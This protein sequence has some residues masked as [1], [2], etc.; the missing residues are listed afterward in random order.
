M[1][2][3]SLVWPCLFQYIGTVPRLV[4]RCQRKTRSVWNRTAA[5]S[6]IEKKATEPLKTLLLL[7]SLQWSIS[8]IAK[9]NLHTSQLHLQE[10]ILTCERYGVERLPFAHIS[11]SDLTFFE[12]FLP[13]R[14][15][16]DAE[17]LKPF[18]VDWLKSVRGCST[19]LLK[20]RTTMEVSQILKYCN[21]KNLAVNPQGGNTGLVGG[22]VPVFDEIILSTGLMNQIISFDH[23]SGILICQAGCILENLNQYL[24]PKGFVMP[25]DLGAKG[26]CH[27]GGNVATNAG[28]L[29]L[30][31]YGS[32]RGTVLGLEVVLADGSILNCLA[33]LRKDNTG[34]DLKQLFIG[35]EGTLGVVTA[36]SILCPRKPNAVNLAFLACLSFSQVLRTF[37][38]CKDMLGEIL[39]AYE[40]MDNGCM[41]LV[42]RHLKLTNPVTES[43]FYVLIETSGSNSSHDEEKLS[44]FLEHVMGSDLV[45][46]GTLASEGKKI[47]ALWALRE[48]ITEAL[49]CDGVV[50]KYDISLPVEK[51]YDLVTD[52]KVRLDTAAKNVVGYGHLGDGNLH[53]NVTAESY[54]HSLLDAIE[55]YVYEW[56]SKY[57]GSIS[58]EHGLGFK[59]KHYIHYSKP[60]EA[61]LLMQQFKVMLDPKGIL[62]PYKTLPSKAE[63]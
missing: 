42:E 13:G 44:H 3:S 56:V 55:P 38:T 24:E 9:R 46:D 37:I 5:L 26:S 47:K 59:K 52:M 10:V 29:R 51:L 48:R 2:I 57:D 31:R 62:N 19:V 16:T 50:Y 43:P 25:L 11:D 8:N 54:S 41:K 21:E 36:V 40:F 60:K 15:I 53:L 7:P 20:P 34:Y 45:V 14:V 12:H 33:S 22:S 4:T 23:I 32:L 18:N 58:A 27:I 49:T 39:S 17:E 35:S 61:V 30:L 6:R 63:Q 1:A 28:G